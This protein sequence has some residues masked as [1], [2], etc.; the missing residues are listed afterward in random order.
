MAFTAD[1]IVERHNRG[2][3][4]R[5]NALFSSIF[6]D[7]VA[8][9]LPGMSFA[10]I[11]T[12]LGVLAAFT[13]A[14]P[15]IKLTPRHVYADENGVAVEQTFTGTHD[16]P[17]ASAEGEVPPTGRAVTFPMIDTFVLRDGKV[18]EHR[19]YY[20]NQLFLSQLGLA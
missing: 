9:E 15:D 7:D 19:V 11:E 10:G 5:D 14:F 2:L 1:E 20:D 8:V 16:G 13:T 4:E 18:V 12:L 17:L 3:H 6:A